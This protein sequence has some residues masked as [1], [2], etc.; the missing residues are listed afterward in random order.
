MDLRGRSYLKDTDL[1]AQEYESLLDVA[2]CL[3]AEK[4]EGREL[5]RLERMNVALL[6]EKAST[7]TRSAFEVAASDQ[8]AH[9]VYMGPGETQLEVK[10][11][12]KD[13]GRVLGRMFAGIAFRGFRQSD[14]EDLAAYSGV[15][16]WNGLTEKWHPTQSLADLLTMRDH[17]SKPLSEVSVCFLGDAAN[18]T[19]TSL[20]CAGALMGMDVR[21]AAPLTRRPAPEIWSQAATLTAVTGAR[22]S[23]TTDPHEAV[24]GVDF[25]YTDVWVSMGEPFELW[26]ERIDE[27]LPYQVNAALLAA[28]DNPD[29]KFLHCLPSLHDT[30][31]EI[32]RRIFEKRGLEALE[33][34]DEVFESQASI[35]FDEA[36]NR[37][38]TIKALMVATLVGWEA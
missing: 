25:V 35:V 20:L 19:C 16:V 9:P 27:L 13:T 29:V 37:L 12:T 11:S 1:T 33:V 28:T 38:H 30:G 21:I 31:T 10:E 23:V 26:D 3:R 17:V 24:A 22:L 14:A 15:P 4:R 7:R 6:F 36:A 18:N 2:A 5:R 34:T 32:G 8:G